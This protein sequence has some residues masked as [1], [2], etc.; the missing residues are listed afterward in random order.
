MVQKIL[1]RNGEDLLCCDHERPQTSTLFRSTHNQSANQPSLN[2][3]FGNR[4]NF[5]RISKWAAEL[6]EHVVDFEKC[7]AIKS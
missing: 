2:D 3:F 6:S 4:D 7:S 1:F 5:D